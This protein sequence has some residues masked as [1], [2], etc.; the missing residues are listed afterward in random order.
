MKKTIYMMIGLGLLLFGCTKDFEEL[1][2]DPNNPPKVSTASLLTNAQKAILDDTR[3]VWWAGR[4]SY[5]WSQYMCQRN[6]TEEDRYLI[7]QNVNNTYWSLHYQNAMDLVE[8]IRLNTQENTREEA[9]V[10]GPNENQIAVA[11]ILKA[12]LMQ[13]MT[14]TWGDIPYFSAFDIENNPSPAYD[15]QEAIYADLIQELTEASDMIDESKP[16]FSTGDIIY[17]GNAERWKKLANSLKLRVAI[18]MKNVPGSNWQIYFDE[19][20]D[21][22]VFES[23]GDNAFFSYIGT[24]PNNSP[25]YDA[26]ITNGRNDL[27]VTK[28]LVDILKGVDDTLNHKI[29]PFQGM[30]DPRL[31]AFISDENVMH[32]GGG[33]PMMVEGIPVGMSNAYTRRFRSFTPNFYYYLGLFN[34]PDAKIAYMTYAEVCFLLSERNDWDQNWYEAGV[35]ASL[36]M[37]GA[38]ANELYGWSGSRFAQYQADAEAYLAAL[39]PATDDRVIT[40]KYIN[41]FGDGYEAWAEV[42][43]TGFPSMLVRPGE[44]T[45]RGPIVTDGEGNPVDVIF[46]PFG[47]ITEIIPRQTYPY[48]EQTLN[49]SNY[50]AAASAIGGDS[51]ATKLWWDKD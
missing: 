46:T 21:A 7:R 19:A 43:R 23:N 39:P 15:T 20:V 45:Y 35:S 6:Y 10:Y 49:A 32:A 30:L 22:G 8:I 27:T 44:I 38:L 47:N 9:S 42:R 25:M 26:F 2:T 36:D 28:Q 37:W 24:D 41:G 18:R 13:M 33:D 29:N 4:Q 3:D 11:K 17:Q 1:N 31:A 16:A 51:H 50:E 48:E 40:Q 14:D 5:P 12:Y 34:Q